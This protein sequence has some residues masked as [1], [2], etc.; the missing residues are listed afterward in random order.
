M[1][2]QPPMPGAVL[3]VTPAHVLSL[4]MKQAIRA[5]AGPGDVDTD[6]I[7]LPPRAVSIAPAPLQPAVGSQARVTC[8][9]LLSLGCE[10]KRPTSPLTTPASPKCSVGASSVSLTELKQVLLTD[11]PSSLPTQPAISSSS[12]SSDG[13]SSSNDNHNPTTPLSDSLCVTKRPTR[14]ARSKRVMAVSSIR[15]RRRHRPQRLPR[16]LS[17]FVVDL[18]WF[19]RPPKRTQD[20]LMRRRTTMAYE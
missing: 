11:S 7:R 20:I 15:V 2:P 9:E 14:T 10:S 4:A 6:M 1:M 18:K 12:I 16:H 8:F 19:H 3:P 5:T 13:S 17:D